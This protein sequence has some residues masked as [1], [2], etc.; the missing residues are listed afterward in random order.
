MVFL[1]VALEREIVA[2]QGFGVGWKEYTSLLAD[3]HKGHHG[4]IEKSYSI[5][6]QGY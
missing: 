6:L 3:D 4:I 1:G 5:G 2:R